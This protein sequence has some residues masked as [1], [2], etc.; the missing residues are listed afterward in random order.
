MCVDHKYGYFTVRAHARACACVSIRL[1]NISNMLYRTMRECKK[2]KKIQ[3]IRRIVYYVIHT[4]KESDVTPRVCLHSVRSIAAIIMTGHR[5]AIISSSSLTS[6][7][8]RKSQHRVLDLPPRENKID[9]DDSSLSVDLIDRVVSFRL[10]F[11]CVR[12]CLNLKESCLF[13]TRDS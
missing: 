11:P 3:Q 10:T 7:V 5:Y 2:K 4:W 6:R 13:L 9:Y 1:S 12:R 8:V